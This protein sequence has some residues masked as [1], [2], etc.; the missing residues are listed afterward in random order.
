MSLLRT[1]AE[2]ADP[3]RKWQRIAREQDVQTPASAMVQTR[4]VSPSDAFSGPATHSHQWRQPPAR[5]SA[6][7]LAAYVVS[8][9]FRSVVQRVVQAYA[10]VPFFVDAGNDRQDYDHPAIKLMNS[11][12]RRLVGSQGRRLEQTYLEVVGESI[13]V[14]FPVAGPQ[15]LEM[16]PVSPTW[17]TIESRAGEPVYI[18][19]MNGREYE[20]AEHEVLH[21]RELD[22]SN[23]YGRGKGGGYAVADEIESD[24]YAAKFSKSYFY[25][26]S[27]P[28][29]IATIKDA[30]PQQALDL[31][32]KFDA[33]HKG[34]RKGW[35]PHF[36]SHELSIHELTRK[37]GDERIDE[38]RKYWADV[39][40]W[41]YGIPPEILGVVENSNRATIQ[42]ARQ[43]M[44]E[45]VTDPRCQYFQETWQQLIAPSFGNPKISYVSPIPKIFDRRDEIMSRHPYHFTRNEIRREGGFSEVR[46]G[47]VYATPVNIAAT[48]AERTLSDAGSRT[49][50]KLRVIEGEK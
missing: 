8:P 2:L 1:I 19:R 23:P 13:T 14:L 48:P 17:V 22:L 45:F 39:V 49:P 3:S 12:N 15:R 34:F 50:F 41:L 43:I 5:G 21:R 40:R 9:P 44:G 38:M 33:K 27:V 7:L 11:Y 30:T 31:Q 6:D 35:Q 20:F 32:A 29:F 10:R 46:D 37:L 18:V 36:T 24:E 26:S 25:N 16:Y 47:D 42:E 28:E 4:A